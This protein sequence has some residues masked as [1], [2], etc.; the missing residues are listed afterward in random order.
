ML[1]IEGGH[2]VIVEAGKAPVVDGRPEERMRVGCGSATVGIFARQ[3]FG[4]VD[5]VIVRGR[6]H[7]RRADRAPGRP[8][9]RHAACRHPRARAASRRRGATSRSP[10]PASAGAAPTS[11][12]RWRSSKRSTPRRPGRA[13]GCCSPPPPART[14][15]IACST[16]SFSPC[17]PRCRR[18]CAESSTASAKTA[19]RRSAPCMFMAG[20]GGSLRAGVTN[21]PVRLTRSVAAGETR[22]TMGGAPVYVWPGGGITVMVDV[23]R[24]P[25]GSF[26]YVPTPAIVA[27]MEFTLPRDLYEGLGGHAGDIVSVADMLAAVAARRASTPGAATIPGLSRPRRGRHERA[28]THQRVPLPLAGR[29]QGRGSSA[30]ATPDP[31]LPRKGGGMAHDYRLEDQVGFIL[32]RAHQRATGIFNAVM[33]EFSITPTQFAAL[34]KLHDLGER[35]AKRARP[36]DR[37]GPGDD[38]WRGE[39][40]DQT[41]L[42]RAVGRRE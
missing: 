32:R 38:F 35:V 9:A 27:P 29:G 1:A 2:E 34:A 11:P 4:E 19:S 18:R 39:P 6:S 31:A 17:P 33:E 30:L 13:F 42:H 24:M 3:W 23:T 37:H 15:S 36:P 7:H 26:G 16:R 25:K 5:E 12:I 8:R 41:R 10:I 14:R 40:P 28:D 22:V 21:N 20:A